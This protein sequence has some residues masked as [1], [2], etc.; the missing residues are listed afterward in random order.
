MIRRD[1]DHAGFTLLELLVA[2]TVLALL[3][4]LLFGGLEFGTRV[5]KV[6][7]A[8][9]ERFARTDTA[10]ALMRRTMMAASPK[11]VFEDRPAADRRAGARSRDSEPAV[12]FEGLPDGVRFIGPAPAA[13]LGGGLYRLAFGVVGQEGVGQL[14]FAWQPQTV[15]PERQSEAATSRVL[16]D[17]IA[18][19]RFAYFGTAR[20]DDAAQWHDRW[21]NQPSLPMI[22]SVQ[23]EFQPRDRRVWPQLLVAPMLSMP[24]Q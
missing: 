14:V 22:V 20:D 6:G 17:G 13:V 5:W 15:E 2:M 11:L 19:A 1:G 10:F 8:E 3:T 12:D 4:A 16:L 7:D 18:R 23:L 9:L 24:L 21:Q